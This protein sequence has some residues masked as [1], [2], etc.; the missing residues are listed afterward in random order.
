MCH[1]QAVFGERRKVHRTN[2]LRLNVRCRRRVEISLATDVLLTLK[3]DP[4]VVVPFRTHGGASACFRLDSLRLTHMK[5][6]DCILRNVLLISGTFWVIGAIASVRADE[7]FTAASLLKLPTLGGKQFWSDEL[8]FWEWR[9]QRNIYSKRCRLLDPRN[10]QVESGSFEECHRRLQSIKARQK[11]RPVSGPV[12]IALHGTGRSRQS[13]QPLCDYL[14]KHGRYTAL[15]VSYAS[16]RARIGQHAK[17]LGRVIAYL[18]PEVTEIN[19]VAHSMGNLV[20]RHYLG[21]QTDARN[22]R[23]PDPRIGR[24][25]MLAPPNQ[26]PQMAARVQDNKLFQLLWGVSGVEMA[27]EWK[28]LSKRLATPACQF[29]IIAGGQVVRGG[30]PL[31]TGDDDLVVSVEETRLAGAHDFLVRPVLHSFIMNDP[32]VQRATLLFLRRAY[33]VSPSKRNPIVAQ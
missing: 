28:H 18:G 8:V 13:M 20:I 5:L 9:I 4:R 19:F 16:T 12:V 14:C 7:P 33:F 3:Y 31:I 29:G 26:G 17:S 27:K 6:S 25:V 24:I 23:R 32:D 15:N 2:Y 21:D 1:W 11:L 10:L 22:Q 30:N